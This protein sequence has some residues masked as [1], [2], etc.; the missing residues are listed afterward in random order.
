MRPYHETKH[1]SSVSVVVT[2]SAYGTGAYSKNGRIV[3]TSKMLAPSADVYVRP[4]AED[5]SATLFHAFSTRPRR[6]GGAH[7]H[8]GRAPVK[9]VR[10][11]AK[12]S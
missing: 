4:V 6:Q 9:I 1:C 12:I 5:L 2:V 8:G 10:D 3:N 7:G 11:P